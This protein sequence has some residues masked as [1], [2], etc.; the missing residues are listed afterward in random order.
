MCTTVE[1]S[2]PRPVGRLPLRG[3]PG[4]HLHEDLVLRA[5][6][7]PP[8]SSPR[9]CLHGRIGHHQQPPDRSGTPTRGWVF[10]R[11]NGS[12]LRRKTVPYYFV[13]LAVAGV[14]HRPLIPEGMP[15]LV[16]EDLRPGPAARYTTRLSG[17]FH[18]PGGPAVL[19]LHCRRMPPFLE[20]AVS[21]ATNTPSA[22]PSRSTMNS[23]RSARTRSSSHAAVRNRRCIRSGL[24]CPACSASHQP[25]FCSIGES[26]PS[27][28]CRAVHR[29]SAR[30]NRSPIRSAR[31]QTPAATP[32]ELHYR[33]RPSPHVQLCPQ[34]TIDTKH[35]ELI[36]S[37]AH[38]GRAWRQAPR[39]VNDHDFPSDTEGVA[40]P[41]AS[42][43]RTTTAAV[44]ASAPA[45]T[46]P[47]SL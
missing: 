27:S 33:Q 10:Q 7:Q 20:V 42:T 45:A 36:G 43:T 38:A 3:L 17:C 2:T 29:G 4:Q 32:E 13:G 12:K 6:R 34:Q 14:E 30:A 44:S 35:R 1:R 21:S 11:S 31:S 41:T 23:R 19:A 40:I 24:T 15:V 37:F 46:H 25:F 47:S 18:P 5:R 22:W 39:P 26:S 28:I 16:D 9:R 8:T